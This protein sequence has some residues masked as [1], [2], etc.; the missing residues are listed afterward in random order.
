[1]EFS[2][3][4]VAGRFFDGV[5]GLQFASPSALES[6]VSPPREDV[7]FWMNAAD[8]ASLCGVDLDAL[9]SFLPSRLPTTHL[10]FHGPRVV[11]VSRRTGRDLEFR[12][13][14]QEPRIPDYMSFVKTLTGR[15][16]QPLP[17]GPRPH[18]QRRAGGYQPVSAG[19][20]RLR[21]RG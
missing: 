13:P 12:V 5:R 4:V 9:K 6:L 20:H 3:E 17:G 10:V 7:V 8:P 21:L 11:L 2:G 1:M 15:D 19:A 18:R 16:Q 14:P